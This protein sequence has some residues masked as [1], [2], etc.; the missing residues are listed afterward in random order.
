MRVRY[1]GVV[2]RVLPVALTVDTY[3]TECGKTILS[4]AAHETDA[5]VS[6][7]VCLQRLFKKGE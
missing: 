4:A 6:C 2:H 7:V 5:E 3:E 1:R